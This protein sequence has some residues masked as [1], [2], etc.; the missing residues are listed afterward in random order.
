[1]GRKPLE[2]TRRKA[3]QGLMTGLGMLALPTT[4]ASAADWEAFLQKHFLELSK[5]E[6]QQT[7]DRLSREYSEK[8]SKEVKAT[9]SIEGVKYGYGLDLSRCIGCRRCVYACVTENNQSR[10]P[11]IH[12]IRVLQLDQEKGVNLNHAEHYYNPE[13]VPEKEHF[14]LP[15]QCQQC[16]NPPAPRSVR[17]RRPGR[18]RTE[19]S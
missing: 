16:E 8:Y 11:Q 9:S 15:V 4:N 18:K 6:L 14:Y 12:W 19:L 3:L 13:T 5:E 17:F 1:M 7:L 10:D 2:I